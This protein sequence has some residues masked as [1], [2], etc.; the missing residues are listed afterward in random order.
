MRLLLNKITFGLFPKQM[1]FYVM[2]R[3]LTD[4]QIARRAD[5]GTAGLMSV[6]AFAAFKLLVARNVL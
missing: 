2:D 1:I 3:K 4:R 6:L 5:F